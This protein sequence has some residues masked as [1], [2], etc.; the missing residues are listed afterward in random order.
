[1]S[2]TPAVV[3]CSASP[4]INNKLEMSG[5]HSSNQVEKEEMQVAVEDLEF[6]KEL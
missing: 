6:L 1:M 2:F 3:C 4:I 5:V